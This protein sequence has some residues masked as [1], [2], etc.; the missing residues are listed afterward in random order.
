MM[1]SQQATILI[2]HGTPGRGHTRT[3]PAAYMKL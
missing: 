1:T 2:I 3:S